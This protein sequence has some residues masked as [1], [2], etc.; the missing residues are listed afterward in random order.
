MTFFDAI[1]FIREVDAMLLGQIIYTNTDMLISL[2]VD[3]YKLIGMVFKFI[4]YQQVGN[5]DLTNH[6]FLRSIEYY[7]HCS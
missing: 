5:W 3:N 6:I 2:C 4:V 1:S 7:Y